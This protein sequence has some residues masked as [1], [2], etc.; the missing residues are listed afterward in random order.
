MPE[1]GRNFAVSLLALLAAVLSFHLGV[2]ASY[3]R[4]ENPDP[5]IFSYTGPLWGLLFL[6]TPLGIGYF[7]TRVPL[8]QTTFVFIVVSLIVK[9]LDLDPDMIAG[10]NL[11]MREYLGEYFHGYLRDCLVGIPVACI[12]A[13]VGVWLQ[14]R[15]NRRRGQGP[16]ALPGRA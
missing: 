11:P 12:I 4:F 6:A 3:L 13:C 1:L 15:R 9:R 10:R 2:S 8:L 16:G 14:R 5:P 7:A